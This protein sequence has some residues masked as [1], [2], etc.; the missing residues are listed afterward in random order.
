MTD[1]R[2]G[3]SYPVGLRQF[4]G[5]RRN[6]VGKPGDLA[7]EKKGLRGSIVYSKFISRGQGGKEY[8]TKNR[9]GVK[10]IRQDQEGEGKPRCKAPW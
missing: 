4:K 9:Q 1:N 7:G 6:R 5:K 2:D 10:P 3:I 8:A